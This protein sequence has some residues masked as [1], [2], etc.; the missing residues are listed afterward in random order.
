MPLY[1]TKCPGCGRE[2]SIFRKIAERD[3]IEPCYC[4]SLPSRILVAPTVR[5]EI[6]AY[7]SPATGELIDSRAKR[8]ED[9]KKSGSLEWEPGIKEDITRRRK[10][11]D[12]AVLKKADE[13]VD[14]MVRHFV[15]TGALET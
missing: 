7:I 13:T 8:R 14:N 10:E 5:P 15:S 11:R 1:Q 9:L 3:R 6:S 4:G 2:A 12:E